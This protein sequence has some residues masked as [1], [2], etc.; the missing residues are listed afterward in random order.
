MKWCNNCQIECEDSMEVCSKCGASLSDVYISDHDFDDMV[1]GDFELLTHIRDNVEAN[2]LISYLNGN[3]I[4]TYVHYEGNGPY[5]TLLIEEGMENTSIFVL[6]DQ[7]D[8]A[9]ELLEQFVFEHES[10]E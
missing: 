4:E 2:V 6:S 9:K 3:G 8:L 5:K 7:L 1:S 10:L